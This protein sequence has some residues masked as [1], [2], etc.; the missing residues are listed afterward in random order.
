MSEITRYKF[1]DPKIYKVGTRDERRGAPVDIY[2]A[3]YDSYITI[4]EHDMQALAEHFRF[5]LLRKRA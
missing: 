4:T 3:S 5:T 1:D 2:S